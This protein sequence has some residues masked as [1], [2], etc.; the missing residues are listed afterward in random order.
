MLKIQRDPR[1]VSLLG[2]VVMVLLWGSFPVV[3]KIGVA[4][5]PPLLLSG[6]R[7]C[8]AFCILAGIAIAQRKTLAMTRRQHFQVFMISLLMV[9][10][11]SSIFFAAAPYAP[12]G[13]L[14]L[15]WSTTPIFTSLFSIGVTGEARGWR[16]LCSLCLGTLGIL[17]VLLGH[18]PFWPGV[19][20]QEGQIFASSGA[21]LAGELAVLGSSVVYGLGMR[22]ARTNSP[23]V[24]VLVLTCWQLLYSGLFIALM[25]LL[26]ERG[27]P[28]SPNWIALGTLL[29]LA[30]FCSC[31]SF[32]LTFW[33]I[34]R[35]G[36]IRTAYSDFVIP[37]VTLVLSYLFLGES[38]T[39]AK[40][41]GMLLVMVSILLVAA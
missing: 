17:I 9:G 41:G 22:T 2:F 12:A 40:V 6:A 14:T 25:G 3:A 36:A 13:V 31:I 29:Y 8:L 1:F 35:I 15:M 10:I 19:G 16:L 11:P 21:A 20:A 30:I 5:V 34:R 28:F 27:Y 37:A 18:V 24:P 23:D 33:L 32:F 26:F 4:Y 7:F 38:L 39:L